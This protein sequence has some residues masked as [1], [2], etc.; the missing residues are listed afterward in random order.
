MTAFDG[1]RGLV[2]SPFPLATAAA[3]AGFLLYECEDPVAEVPA[4]S[5]A[6]VTVAAPDAATADFIILDKSLATRVEPL[7]ESSGD[8][9]GRRNGCVQEVPSTALDSDMLRPYEW[10]ASELVRVRV[11]SSVLLLLLLRLPPLFLG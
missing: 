4:P 2:E 6:T 11:T 1:V 7:G 5:V 8:A 3:I 10:A 9:D